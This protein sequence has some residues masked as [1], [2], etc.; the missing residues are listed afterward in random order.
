MRV[1]DCTVCLSVRI[2]E[3]KSLSPM[4]VTVLISLFV[5]LYWSV[6]THV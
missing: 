5:L 1:P 6:T 2:L 3:F 4:I